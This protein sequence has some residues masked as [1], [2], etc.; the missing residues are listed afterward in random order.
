MTLI[1]GIRRRRF[2][3]K[4]RRAVRPDD[5]EHFGVGAII[6]PPLTVS[7]RE[8]VSVGE[9][10]FIL[11]GATISLGAEGH[12][13]IG[14]RT[15]LGRDLTIVA[16]QGVRIGDDVLGS[17]RIVVCDT[18]PD[19]RDPALPVVHQGVAPARPVVVEDGVFL[20]TGAMLLPGVTIGARSF[21]GA[22]SVVTHDVPPNS[23]AVGNPARVVR[24]FD[25]QTGG[26]V[27]AQLP[28]R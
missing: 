1:D 8:R 24:T 14:D 7:A 28:G 20:G 11:E 4:V 10:S 12:V 16:L 27:D 22:G 13:Q 5:F 25:H 18:A 26:W 15:Y 23:L 3:R 2:R 19:P 9:N 21:I 6:H 17:D